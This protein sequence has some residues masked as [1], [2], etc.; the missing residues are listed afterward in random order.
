MMKIPQTLCYSLLLLLLL[1][2][3]REL[4]VMCAAAPGST[5]RSDMSALSES[6]D[7][8]EGLSSAADC[9]RRSTGR[10]AGDDYRPSVISTSVPGQSVDES[11]AYP[12]RGSSQTIQVPPLRSSANSKLG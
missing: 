9:G 10:P 1:L 5:R 6:P 3:L 4:C 12:L 7:S 2:L 8:S 11:L